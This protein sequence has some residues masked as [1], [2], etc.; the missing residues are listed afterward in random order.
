M[1]LKELSRSVVIQEPGI[2]NWE[3]TF[4]S[5]ENFLRCLS[6][7]EL[8]F[9]GGIKEEVGIAKRGCKVV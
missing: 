9:Y 7:Q 5:I 3:G 1:P 4:Y 6:R 2:F 8:L